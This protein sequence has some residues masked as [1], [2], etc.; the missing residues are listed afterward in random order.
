[1]LSR[2]ITTSG[3]L[4]RS[5]TCCLHPRM[6]QQN[7]NVPKISN[8]LYNQHNINNLKSPILQQQR[9][10]CSVFITEQSLQQK[11]LEATMLSPSPQ[12]CDYLRSQMNLQQQ[13]QQQQVKQ[14]RRWFGKKS[15][16]KKKV[17]VEKYQKTTSSSSSSPVITKT[18]SIAAI[19]T[20]AVEV[21]SSSDNNSNDHNPM[22]AN[23]SATAPDDPLASDDGKEYV[24]KYKLP[25]QKKEKVLTDIQTEIQDEY[26]KGKYSKALKIAKAGIKPIQKHFGDDHPVTASTYCNIGLLQKLLGDY[27]ESRR[28]YKM[29]LKIYK[30]VVGND[31]SSYASVLHNLGNLNRSQIHFDT[32]LKVDERLSLIEDSIEHLQEALS[33][34]L[35]ELGNEHAH[36]VITKSSLGIALATHVLHQYKQV[37]KKTEQ[38]NH[39]QQN[40]A[41]D[42][43]NATTTISLIP[44]STN[45]TTEGWDAAE[46]YLRKALKTAIDNPR[47]QSMKKKI[48]SKKKQNI[49]KKMK[50]L[51]EKKKK[52]NNDDANDDENTAIDDQQKAY[53]DKME[54]LSSAT[55]GQ[56]LAV[57]LKARATI[58]VTNNNEND[59]D[60][61][62]GNDDNNDDNN[63]L[64]SNNNGL[65]KKGQEEGNKEQPSLV[66]DEER[67]QEEI[68]N[69]KKIEQQIKNQEEKDSLLLESLTLY[70]QVLK[71]RTDILS[72]NVKHP[73]I[74]I[75]KHSLAELLDL[76]GDTEN[77]NKI[78]QDIIDTYD[79]TYLGNK[80]NNDNENENDTDSSNKTT[81]I[82]N[83]DFNMIPNNDTTIVNSSADTSDDDADD[84]KDTLHNDQIRTSNSTS[85]SIN[86]I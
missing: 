83:D 69:R 85:S 24:E 48:K 47:G 28:H 3:C 32:T 49:K 75:T 56:N 70:K 57:F 68:N 40:Q 78:R 63:D 60:S 38:M 41:Q 13:Q 21:S 10:L 77:A 17:R 1:M 84:T 4:K 52:D 61:N 80:Q 35:A 67:Q 51:K 25:D 29:A 36:T 12:K 66:N 73:D 7:N 18:S 23:I 20:K 55:A 26:K 71:V 16:A 19:E 11:I 8:A 37:T 45:V 58:I 6:V 81:T 15:K 59:D 74:Y 65:T 50:E 30:N 39:L 86:E 14:T 72:E 9:L 31:H 76:M 53:Y 22:L 44:T 64:I 54:T 42:S 5:T 82:V 27:I 2:A 43:T 62:L 34:R 46:E 33:I 79:D